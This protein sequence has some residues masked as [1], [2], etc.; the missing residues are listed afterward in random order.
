MDKEI[1]TL[2][3]LGIQLQYAGEQY[4]VQDSQTY[5]FTLKFY[6]SIYSTC[7]ILCIPRGLS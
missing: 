2:S 5:S 7:C 3:S 1:E 4:S 6:S